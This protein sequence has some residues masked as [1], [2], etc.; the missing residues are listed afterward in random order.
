[1][2]QSG[3]PA[4]NNGRYRAYIAAACLRACRTAAWSFTGRICNTDVRFSSAANVSAASRKSRSA[5]F[6]GSDASKACMVIRHRTISALGG[7][8][9]ESN[10]AYSGTKPPHC[11]PRRQQ[12]VVQLMIAWQGRSAPVAGADHLAAG[13]A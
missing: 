7:G 2:P 6:R 8:N 9:S 1:M 11:A 10:K 4:R 3:R 13:A 12:S 5:R